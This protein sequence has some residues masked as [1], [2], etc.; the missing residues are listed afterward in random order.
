M[1]FQAPAEDPRFSP[2]LFPSHASLPPAFVTYNGMDPL[3]DDARL[4]IKVLRE[5]GVKVKEELYPLFYY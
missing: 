1:L 5:A 2:L 4:W 3:R